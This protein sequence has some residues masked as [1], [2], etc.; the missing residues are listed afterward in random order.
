VDVWWKHAEPDFEPPF[1]CFDA[2]SHD[3]NGGMRSRFFRRA[4][5]VK[6]CAFVRFRDFNARGEQEVAA[7]DI[8]QWMAEGK[9]KAQIDRILPCRKPLRLIGLQEESTSRSRHSEGENRLSL[10]VFRASRALSSLTVWRQ[11]LSTLLTVRA[12]PSKRGWNAHGQNQKS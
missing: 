3:R 11:A 2:G 7:T 10:M 5:Y 12:E 1:R 8:N 6:D 9:L 4:F